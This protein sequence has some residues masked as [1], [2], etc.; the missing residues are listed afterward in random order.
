MTTTGSRDDARVVA[1]AALEARHA[2][3]V[4]IVG[5][6]ESHY[7]WKGR[8]EVTEEWLC[9]AKTSADRVES[10]IATIRRA[11]PYETPEI[12]VS[13]LTGGSADYLA[14]IDAETR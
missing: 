12:T 14:W 2:A 1:T 10:L 7:W 4:Q 9:L 13:E 8:L 3:C 6:I 11:H 5:P